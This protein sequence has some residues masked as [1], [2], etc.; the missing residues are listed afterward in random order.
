[1]EE[2]CTRLVRSQDLSLRNR[3]LLEEMDKLNAQGRGADLPR[4]QEQ[5]ERDRCKIRVDRQDLEGTQR[6]LQAHPVEELGGGLD[7]KLN[8][9]FLWGGHPQLEAL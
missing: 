2:A 1:M 3:R 4:H 7:H 8:E 6:W 5:G 9:G